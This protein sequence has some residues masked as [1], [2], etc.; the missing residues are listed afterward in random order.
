MIW[1]DD[2]GAYLFTKRLEQGLFVWPF[3][4]EGKISLS[5]PQLAKPLEGID[6]RILKKT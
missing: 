4:K 6:W 1:W 5:R 3:A 2:Q